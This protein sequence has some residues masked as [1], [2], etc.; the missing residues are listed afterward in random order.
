MVVILLEED[1]RLFTGYLA[2]PDKVSLRL[3]TMTL[4]LTTKIGRLV[5]VEEKD[6]TMMGQRGRCWGIC[7]ILADHFAWIGDGSCRREMRLGSL[8][9]TCRLLYLDEY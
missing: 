7:K 4:S 9:F 6:G 8:V 3:W 1:W 5:A 2:S